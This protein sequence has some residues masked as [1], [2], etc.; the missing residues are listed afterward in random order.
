MV[1]RACCVG[2]LLAVVC[3]VTVLGGGCGGTSTAPTEVSASELQAMMIDGNPI[4]LLD[5]R[6]SGEYAT[7]HIPGSANVPLDLVPEWA[8]THDRASRVATICGSGVRSLNAARTLMDRGYA[9]V[10][11]LR[12]GVNQ[13]PGALETN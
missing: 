11:S 1:L 8:D 3:G 7:G 2:L 9:N 10:V 4:A 12:G 5:V 6:T 13:W